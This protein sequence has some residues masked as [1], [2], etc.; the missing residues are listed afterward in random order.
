[1]TR[2][3]RAGTTK[4]RYGL[5]P[6]GTGLNSERKQG[7]L[8]DMALVNL[9]DVAVTRLN[10]SGNGFSVL[11]QTVSGDKT[12]KTYWSVWPKEPTGVTVGEVVSMSG[13]LSTK[14]GELK[15][16]TDGVERRYVELSINSPRLERSQSAP[17][18]P[19]VNEEPWTDGTSYDES[20]F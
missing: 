17:S 3:R 18:T 8:P 16:G 5:V 15:T 19:T 11:E 13:F 2:N 14:V 6:N 1:V 20:P 7:R 10:N 9:K 12:Y 4:K